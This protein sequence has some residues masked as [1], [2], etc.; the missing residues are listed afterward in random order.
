MD[1]IPYTQHVIFPEDEQAVLRAL[2]SGYLTQGPEVEALEEAFAL[3]VGARHAVAVSSG[4][5]AIHLACIACGVDPDSIVVTTPVTFV[6]TAN[7]VL[8]CG[9]KVEFLDVDPRTGMAVSLPPFGS[10][11]VTLGGQPLES[12]AM[13]VD[14]SHGPYVYPKN[15]HA[16]C[17]SLHASKHI[18]AGEGGMICTNDWQVALKCITLR[19]H[20]R[21]RTDGE[22]RMEMYGVNYRLDEM[23]AALARS[24]LTRLDWSITMRRSIAATYDDAFRGKVATVPHSE[25]SARHL[26]QLLLDDRDAQQKTLAKR[27]IGTAKH[28]S[29]IVPLQPYW[30][31]RFGYQEGM[32]PNAEKFAAQTLSI[33]LFPTM[34]DQQIEAVITAVLE[35]CG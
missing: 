28:Y 26:Y 15:A 35:V 23:S 32:W 24:Q 1:M 19:D 34:T 14:A 7:A 22:K 5:A 30:K 31:T 27:G 25:D 11:G 18:A 29:P 3:K 21:I 33:P 13:I 4:T 12:R 16:A 2:R 10:I 9:A 8:Y 20:G 17:W 6:A